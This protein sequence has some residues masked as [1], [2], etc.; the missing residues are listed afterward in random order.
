LEPLGPHRSARLLAPQGVDKLVQ[1]AQAGMIRTFHGEEASEVWRHR[2]T[3]GV[4]PVYQYLR[5]TGRDWS[6]GVL[7]MM[8]DVSPLLW[9][10]SMVRQM[11]Y[12]HSHEAWKY[13]DDANSHYARHYLISD[14]NPVTI[15]WLPETDSVS[16]KFSRGQFGV[17]RRTIAEADRHIGEVVAE[18]RRCGRLNRTYLFLVS[19]HGHHGGRHGHLSHFDIANEFFF[20]PR[21]LSPDGHW[22]GGGLGLSVRQH[23][24]WN[25]HHGDHSRSFVF[26]DGDSDGT[27][28]IFLPRQC[29]ESKQWMGPPRPGDLLAYPIAEHRAPVNLVESLL[30]AEMANGCGHVER[31]VDLVLLKLSDCSILIATC[32]RGHAVIDRTRAEDGR[33]LY[34]YT[35][36]ENVHPTPDGQIAF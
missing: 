9:T 24:T 5:W 35:P 10:R 19:D 7:P 32:D 2:Q 23:R 25:R 3:S 20:K 36:V 12:F 30:A 21:V 15:I 26:I 16:H 6:T 14:E 29:Y 1:D 28:R 22:I 31:P 11:P 18:L 33:W 34:R 17:T 27:A 4:A 13:I 8:T